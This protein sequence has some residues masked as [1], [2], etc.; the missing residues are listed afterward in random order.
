MS[1]VAVYG[2]D[3]PDT[4]TSRFA[5]VATADDFDIDPN[6]TILVYPDCRYLIRDNCTRKQSLVFFSL[7]SEPGLLSLFLALYDGVFTPH[8]TV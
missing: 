4:A 6:T 5:F 8:T 2:D 1:R 7:G 3:D